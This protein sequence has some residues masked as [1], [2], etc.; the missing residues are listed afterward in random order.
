M[1][2]KANIAVTPNAPAA[3]NPGEHSGAEEDVLEGQR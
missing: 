2:R 1:G 3:P